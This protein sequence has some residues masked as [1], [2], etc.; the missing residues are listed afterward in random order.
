MVDS[1]IRELLAEDPIRERML[2]IWQTS[3]KALGR[4]KSTRN[5]VAHSQIIPQRTRSRQ[6]PRLAAPMISTVLRSGRQPARGQPRGLSAND[7]RL[8]AAAVAKTVN[9][10]DRFEEAVHL[11]R[12]GDS[13]ALQE[14]LLALEDR[15]QN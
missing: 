2:A 15:Q 3:F 8:S 14:K 6:Q 1:A 4:Y 11:W 10:I 5:K 7:L 9:V 12:Q 13:V